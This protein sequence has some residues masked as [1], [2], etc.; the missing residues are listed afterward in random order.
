MTLVLPACSQI[1]FEEA[2]HYMQ[3]ERMLLTWLR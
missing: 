1:M 3:N 2:D